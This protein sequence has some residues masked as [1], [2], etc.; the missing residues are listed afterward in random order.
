MNTIFLAALLLQAGTGA[1]QGVLLDARNS[2]PI[3][4]AQIA[5]S[6]L[7]ALDNAPDIPTLAAPPARLKAASDAAG[8]FSFRNLPPGLYRIE[9]E[10]EGY[11]LESRT[12]SLVTV[13]DGRAITL[14]L[15]LVQ[16]SVIA[17]RVVD[18]NGEPMSSVNVQ[19]STIF[20][21]FGGPV[22]GGVASQTTDDRGE[23]RLFWV[24]PGEL[25]VSVT[26]KPPARNAKG[27]QNLKTF[28]PDALSASSATPVSVHAG[29]EMTGIDIHVRAGPLAKIAGQVTRAAPPAP[30][31]ATEEGIFA[32]IARTQSRSVSFLMV[33]RDDNI[34][35]RDPSEL[36]RTIALNGSSATFEILNVP[37]GM[38]DLYALTNDPNDSIA[39]G[40]TTIDVRG[41]DVN[42]VRIA[43]RP[44]VDVKG[45]VA[46]DGKAPGRSN[47]RVA[48]QPDG[49]LLRLGFRPQPQQ[50]A[51]DGSFTLR[52]V[53]EGHYRLSVL[54]PISD[55]YVE[56]VRSSDVNVYD[57]GLDIDSSLR[58]LQVTL[59]SG[60][61]TLEGNTAPGAIAALIPTARR[62]NPVLY[63]QTIAD[64]SGRFAMRNLTPGEYKLF[65]WRDAPPG[66]IYNP[67]FV[68]K[69]EAQGKS[70]TVGPGASAAIQ[71]DAI[72]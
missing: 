52:G 14:S 61:G 21:Q 50:V 4:G 40:R 5:L 57:S 64:A 37:A 38:Y 43:I 18:S 71:I 11:F 65:A 68:M 30:P 42:D 54:S 36:S 8:A 48:L 67:A 58:P 13:T 25:Y 63:Y 60:A 9:P 29:E 3:A 66:A 27:S 44:G 59:R 33:P 55:T 12:A 20:Y 51:A 17:G 16:G 41:Q 49:P 31:P 28:Y 15:R 56:T 69:Y 72:Q 45:T 10:V 53:P 6:R 35:D 23:Y 2:M 34:L 47:M 32:I 26:P 1:I 24:P 7:P 62:E 70:V 39:F 22:L 46:L 19:A